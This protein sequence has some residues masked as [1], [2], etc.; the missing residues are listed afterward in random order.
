LEISQKDQ[1]GVIPWEQVMKAVDTGKYMIIY[2]TRM[3]AY[4][5][6]KEQMEQLDKIKEIIHSGCQG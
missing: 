2:I 4:I 5:F 3:R 1:S 6:P